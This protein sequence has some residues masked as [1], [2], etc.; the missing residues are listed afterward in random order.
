MED[1]R[2]KTYHNKN[3]KN[4]YFISFLS[5]IKKFKFKITLLMLL[6]FIIFFPELSGDI[7]GKWINEFIGA[8]IKNIQF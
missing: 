1:I 3:N 8:I 7:I 6:S 4:K 2:I 5:F